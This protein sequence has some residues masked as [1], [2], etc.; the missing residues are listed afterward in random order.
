MGSDVDLLIKVREAPKTP[1][2]RAELEI[3]IEELAD[4]PD[5][6]PFEFHIVD[7][8]G[9]QRYIRILGVKPVRVE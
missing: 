7:E 8:K 2:E 1:R 9:F 5:N 3:R 6:H 4:L